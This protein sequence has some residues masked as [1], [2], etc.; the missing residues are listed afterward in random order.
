MTDHLIQKSCFLQMKTGILLKNESR[1]TFVPL[2]I[3]TAKVQITQ[4]YWVL[5]AMYILAMVIMGGSYAIT[6]D[7]ISCHVWG[8]PVR[9]IWW[10]RITYIVFFKRRTHNTYDGEPTLLLIM[11]DC[12]VYAKSNQDSFSFDWYVWTHLTRAVRIIGLSVTTLSGGVEY[13]I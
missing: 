6:E 8:I 12:P 7:F 9:K 5:A 10:E 1:V 3:V 13:E 11:K 2:Q 4:Y